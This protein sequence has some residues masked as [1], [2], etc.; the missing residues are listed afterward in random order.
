MC[1]MKVPV[2]Q[3]TFEHRVVD[4]TDTCRSR[5]WTRPA[6]RASA[7]SYGLPAGSAVLTAS[8]Q[9]AGVMPT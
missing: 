3:R 8:Q 5:S 6:F 4:A 7:I 2:R 1:V 9:P